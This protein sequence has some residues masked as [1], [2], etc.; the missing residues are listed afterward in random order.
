MHGL[1]TGAVSNDERQGFTNALTAAFFAHNNNRAKSGE[2]FEEMIAPRD[3]GAGIN[4]AYSGG[5]K[6]V[7][8]Q[9]KGDGTRRRSRLEESWL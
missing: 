2:I 9:V 4:V 8:K 1:S 6:D 5:R 3:G 7:L